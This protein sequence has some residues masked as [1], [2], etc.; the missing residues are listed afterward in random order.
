MSDPDDDGE[1]DFLLGKTADPDDLAYVIYTSGSTGRPKGV[2]ITHRAA[3]NT[4]GDILER[5]KLTEYDRTL[6][7][8]ALSFDLSVF[9][10][11][12]LLS[13]GGAVVSP[14]AGAPDPAVWVAMVRNHRVTVWNSVPAIMEMT[15]DYLG[16]AAADQLS[17][18]RLVMLSGDWISVSLPERI[19]SIAP[20]VQI[21]ALGGA[22]EASI[23]SNAFSIGEINRSWKSVPYGYP[24]TN[25]RMH[26]LD[27]HLQPVP[28]WVPGDLYI[29]GSG[30]A[31]GYHGD[32]DKTAQSFLPSPDGVGRLYRT[33]DL[34]RY[35]PNGCVEF[36][37]RKDN[38]VKID[39]YRIELGEVESTLIRYPLIH[40][41]A[42]VV[43]EDRNGNRR[44]VAY[45]VPEKGRTLDVNQVCA[46]MR[47]WLPAHMVPRHV[48][49]VDSLPLTVNGKVDRTGLAAAWKAEPTASVP[50]APR[51]DIEAALV[52]AWEYVLDVSGISITD[53]FFAL[54]GSSRAAVQL[55]NRVRDRLGATIPLRSLFEQSTV[56]SQAVLIKT[57]GSRMTAEPSLVRIQP[58]SGM[59]HI[60]VVHPIGGGVLCYRELADGLAPDATVLGAQHPGLDGAPVSGGTVEDL[61][62]RYVN[63]IQRAE[64]PGE[65]YL[66]G[67]SMGGLIAYEMAHQLRDRRMIDVSRTFMIDSWV[68]CN[69]SE[70]SREID[71]GSAAKEFL[72]D[73]VGGAKLPAGVDEIDCSDD[74]ATVCE[75]LKLLKAAGLVGPAMSQS[76]VV[77]LFRVYVQNYEAL[78]R[79]RPPPPLG[80]VDLFI[81]RRASMQ[82]DG[83]VPAGQVLDRSGGWVREFEV[84]ADHFTIVTGDAA[85]RVA[86]TIRH[87]L[88]RL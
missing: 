40:S 16:D 25:Q 68:A 74:A 75:G 79:Y 13:V 31:L 69:L 28:S 11:F 58:G 43:S 72:H 9:D 5:F 32:P 52:E 73:L 35:W 81:A 66:L 60:L 71:A 10:I 63:Q 76:D 12:G 46:A 23:W 86:N 54:G 78:R 29:A 44:M 33:G 19:R 80:P 64:V 26:V 38:Q 4:V 62:R 7:L 34:A 39:G 20:G 84:D 57:A 49:V 24:L 21:V 77:R 83:L 22:T 37:G 53:D 55:M 56:E 42:V 6:G 50:I 27:R 67:W 47:K 45:A 82:R 14:G 3:S 61:A 17:S 88:A 15:L 65:L 59:R 51:S 41:A 48:A 1:A 2:A 85:A 18:L 87:A 30:L 8:S 70:G 36:L